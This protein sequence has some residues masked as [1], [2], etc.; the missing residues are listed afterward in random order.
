M[1]IQQKSVRKFSAM[2]AGTMIG[3]FLGYIADQ[4]L[5]R[6]VLQHSENI[7]TIIMTNA[8]SAFVVFPLFIIFGGVI[9]YRIKNQTP[10]KNNTSAHRK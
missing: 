9:G 3:V 5:T 7:A 1:A 2:M 8:V 10:R 6:Y 4:S